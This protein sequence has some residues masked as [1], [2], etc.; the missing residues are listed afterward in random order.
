MVSIAAGLLAVPRLLI[1][2]EPTLG[3]SP[4]LRQEL[5]Q[6]IR[7]IK[8]MGVPLIVIDQDVAFLSALIDRLYLFD[9]GRIARVLTRAEIPDHATLMS[10]LF[11]A[12]IT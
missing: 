4:K 6:S 8:D 7:T 10:M 2:D 12:A 9:H 11:G 5:C 1:L 3:L